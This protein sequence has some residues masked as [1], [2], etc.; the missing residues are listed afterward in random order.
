MAFF[1]TSAITRGITYAIHTRGRLG[2]LHDLSAGGRHIHHFIPGAV[3]SM[4]AGAISLAGI[5]PVAQLPDYQTI[6][7]RLRA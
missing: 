5:G 7:E 6:S 2:P 4:V 3:L 1:A